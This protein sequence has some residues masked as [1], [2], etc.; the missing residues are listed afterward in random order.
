VIVSLNKTLIHH[1]ESFKA[2][3]TVC[4]L[5]WNCL[6]DIEPFGS[7]WIS[8]LY[9]EKCWNGIFSTKERM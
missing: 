7:H 2:L 1:L 4:R 8:P 9:G 3:W 5:H 6:L